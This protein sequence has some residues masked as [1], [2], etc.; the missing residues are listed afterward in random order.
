MISST[1]V[2]DVLERIAR[3]WAHIDI[4]GDEAFDGMDISD[5]DIG[6][7][8]VTFFDHVHFVERAWQQQLEEVKA[9]PSWNG[10][11]GG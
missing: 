11:A 2:R 10:A 4:E 7:P 3:F 1:S 6:L 8:I 9:D 5:E